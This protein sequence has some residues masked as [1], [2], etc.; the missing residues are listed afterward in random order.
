[1][2][3]NK[4]NLPDAFVKY[5]TSDHII[6]DNRYSVTELLKPVKE[7]LLYREH[8]NEIDVDV[9]DLIPALFGTAVHNIL[10]E[11]TV[12]T[13]TLIPEYALETQ[14]EG[15]T[16]AGRIDLVDFKKAIIT[17]YKT[18]SVNKIVKQD[19][20]DWKL[21]GLAYAYLLFREKG[22]II[23]ELNFIALLKDWS[24]LKQTGPASPIYIW[25]YNIADSDYDYIESYLKGKIAIIKSGIAP[26]CTDAERWNTGD[27]YAVYKKYSDKRATILCDSEKEAN[28]YIANKLNGDGFYQLRKGENIKCKYYCDVCKF[29]KKG[30]I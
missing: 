14:F 10:E 19:F 15:I 25:K 12:A 18:C 17:D 26:D 4:L 6:V 9:S 8:S 27:K 23:R 3:T 1:M 21:Q 20:N 7:I 24:K 5:A 29:C 30:N 28:D 11:N 16:I 22:I 2:I 13:D